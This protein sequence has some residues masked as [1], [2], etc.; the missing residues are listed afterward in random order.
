MFWA[1][2]FGALNDN[3][4]KN[5]LVILVLYRGW[6]IGDLEPEKFAVIAG[7]IFITPFLLFSAWGGQLAGEVKARQF[8][9]HFGLPECG[10]AQGVGEPVGVPFEA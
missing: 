5:A 8:A 3:V 1:Q 9:A 6:T 4:F 10:L 7:A 2:F